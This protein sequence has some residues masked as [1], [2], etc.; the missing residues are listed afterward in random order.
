MKKNMVSIYIY[1]LERRF[2]CFIWR[3]FRKNSSQVHYKC[4][5]TIFNLTLA[6]S[7]AVGIFH[8]YL[9]N[10][11]RQCRRIIKEINR[12]ICSWIGF[13]MLVIFFFFPFFIVCFFFC[14]FG[15]WFNENRLCIKKNQ[16]TRVKSK[17]YHV[18]FMITEVVNFP[19]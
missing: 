9:G 17:I 7:P 11:S 5:N 2:F 8:L 12:G 10:I 6:H 19:L 1:V 18:S 16:L 3:A 4:D 15:N 13:S 14:F